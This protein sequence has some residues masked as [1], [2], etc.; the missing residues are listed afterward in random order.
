MKN[1]FLI[2]VFFAV[3]FLVSENQRL[4]ADALE[5]MGFVEGDRR[6]KKIIDPIRYVNSK[7]V[8]VTDG[9]GFGVNGFESIC[10]TVSWVSKDGVLFSE[11][12]GN[13]FFVAN[14]PY[15]LADGDQLGFGWMKDRYF[16][17]A[18]GVYAYTTVLGASR[19]VH[20]Y[21]YYQLT[22]PPPK[23]MT[24]EEIAAAKVAAEKA[25]AD[26]KIVAA[27]KKAQSA[28]ATIKF[29]TDKANAGDADA[30]NRLGEIYRDG[31]YC[32][33][34]IPTARV[35]FA[36]AAAQGNAKAADALKK[37]SE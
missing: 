7:A 22:P 37:L 30:Q 34:D 16:A 15:Q 10:G 20:K 3:A 9:N 28:V 21:D 1:V 23:P 12:G 4:K 26:A 17:K 8:N 19:T 27:K 31:E 6:S 29:Y 18:D 33:K 25:T 36:K 24:P 14:F 32:A 5:R 13:D 11:P 35:W 2:A